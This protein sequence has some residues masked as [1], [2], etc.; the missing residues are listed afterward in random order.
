[1]A[2]TVHDRD[3]SLANE[4]FEIGRQS[5]G[6]VEEDIARRLTAIEQKEAELK[7]KALVL[8]VA[9]YEWARDAMQPGT[10]V[11]FRIDD[12]DMRES[13]AF[14]ALLDAAKA[15]IRRVTP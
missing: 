10:I 7:A 9:E 13:L 12:V 1:M 6:Y 2:T 5:A 11:M 8:G 15:N 3:F 14:D 4:A